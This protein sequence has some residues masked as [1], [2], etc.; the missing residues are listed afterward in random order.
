MK[1]ETLR[2]MQAP[3][4]ALYKEVPE[5][6]VLTWYLGSDRNYQ[7]NIIFVIP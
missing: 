5:K 1:A 7:K 4:K 3:F 2:E 6:A